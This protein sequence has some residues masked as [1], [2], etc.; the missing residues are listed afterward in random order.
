LRDHGVRKLQFPARRAIGA[1]RRPIMRVCKQEVGQGAKRACGAPIGKI[2]RQRWAKS[3]IMAHA[4][5]TGEE[6]TMDSQ[7]LRDQL[8]RLHVELSSAHRAD[9]QNRELL[10]DVMQDIKRLLEPS[11]VAAPAGAAA[12]GAAS[13]AERLEGLAV[14]FEADHPALAVSTRR[15]I[16]LL[17]KVGV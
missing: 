10:A 12:P 13:I 5:L 8:N 2:G 9:P 15:F 17:G 3:R 1:E 4:A 6:S 11:G 7:E 14:Q 16:D